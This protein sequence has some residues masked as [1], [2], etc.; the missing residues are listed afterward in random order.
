MTILKQINSVLFDLDGTL[1][2]TAPDLAYTLNVMLEQENAPP[3]PYVDVRHVCSLGSTGLLKLGFNLDPD[4]PK[5]Q[6]YRQKFLELYDHYLTI[7]TTLIPGMRKTLNYLK[8]N[9]I[10]WGVVTNKPTLLAQKLLDKFELT[11]F[12]H[13]LVGGDMVKEPKPAPDSLLLACQ[14][15]NINAN[16][17]IYVGDAKRDIDAAKAANID[18]VAALYGYIPDTDNP[19]MWQADYHI[20]KPTEL[21]QLINSSKQSHKHL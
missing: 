11:Y 17:C 4:H 6:H 20:N 14:L 8:E 7:N 9:G 1:L 18:S 15:A 3:L 5:F 16:H 12:C 2:D 21:I 10:E 19:R 13:C